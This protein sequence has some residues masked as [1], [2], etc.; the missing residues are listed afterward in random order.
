MSDFTIF[1][2]GIFFGMVLTIIVGYIAEKRT[3]IK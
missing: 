2:I 1:I 3:E